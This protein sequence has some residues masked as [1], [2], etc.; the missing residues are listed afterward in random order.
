MLLDKEY[1]GILCSRHC[2]N[3]LKVSKY[4]QI[5]SKKFLKNL[6]KFGGIHWVSR[7]F[8]RLYFIQKILIAHLLHN[9]HWSWHLGLQV[10]KTDK[11]ASSQRP[12]V[13][14]AELGYQWDG[15][16]G[17]GEWETWMGKVPAESQG[18]T[19][20]GCKEAFILSWACHYP[21][22]IVQ[23]TFCSQA[24]A[25]SFGKWN[26]RQDPGLHKGREHICLCFTAVVDWIPAPFTETGTG[27][28]IKQELLEWIHD[29]LIFKVLLSSVNSNIA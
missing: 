17:W 25:I 10:N 12:K 15:Q 27:E 1:T 23:A 18:G 26:A 3:F 4:F 5:S 22:R 2:C 19:W 7:R 11:C 20:P 8:S 24:W 28:V 6:E 21:L 13:L 16:L 14:V 9:G 29:L